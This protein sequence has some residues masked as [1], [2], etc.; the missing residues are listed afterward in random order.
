MDLLD[1]ANQAL[2]TNL[3]FQFIMF[4]SS[5]IRF[6]KLSKWEQ[7]CVSHERSHPLLNL[8][9]VVP[10]ENGVNYVVQNRPNLLDAAL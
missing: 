3:N 9:V 1:A 5:K 4:A 8:M 7:Q 2:V 6:L 10:F